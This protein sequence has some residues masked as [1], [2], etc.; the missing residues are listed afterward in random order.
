MSY[1]EIGAALGLGRNHVAT[2]LYR[3][4]QQLRQTLKKE[5]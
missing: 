1:D 3:A 2:L 4:K 5:N